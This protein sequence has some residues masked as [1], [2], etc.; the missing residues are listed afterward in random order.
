MNKE[1]YDLDRGVIPYI[2]VKLLGN[3]SIGSAFHVGDGVFVTARHIVEK[4]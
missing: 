2:E 4:V 3:I 1:L